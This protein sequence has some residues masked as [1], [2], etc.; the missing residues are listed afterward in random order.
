M[1]VSLSEL[2]MLVSTLMTSDAGI[3][4]T[5]HKSTDPPLAQ[6]PSANPESEALSKEM[7]KAKD[8]NSR[9]EVGIEWLITQSKELKAKGAPCLH[10]YTMGDVE[11]IRRVAEVVY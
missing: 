5:Y 1:A 4:K 7:M 2:A 3:V 6:P 10:Y 8:S 11:T 9:K